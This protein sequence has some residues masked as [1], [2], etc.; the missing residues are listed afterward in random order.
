MNLYECEKHVNLSIPYLIIL[1]II[2]TMDI[3]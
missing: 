2:N 1:V 3:V